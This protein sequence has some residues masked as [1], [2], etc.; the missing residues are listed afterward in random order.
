MTKRRLG[1][2]LDALFGG[3][4]YDEFEAEAPVAISADR[5]AIEADPARANL[6][7]TLIDPNP[8]QPRR[9]FDPLDLASLVQSIQQHGLIQPI[10]VRRVGERFQLVAGERR[11]R[12]A[13]EAGLAEVPARVI[14]ADDQQVFE[15]AI[16]ENLQRTDLNAI[17]K[18]RAFRD[19][20]ERFGSTQDE[21]ANR[22]SLDRS[23]VSNFIRLLDLPQ[24]I[25]QAVEVG[26]LSQGHARALLAFG[27]P[28]KQH[29]VCRRI[30]NECLSV[31]QVEALVAADRPAK[32]KAKSAGNPHRT[33]HVTELEGI[34]RECL[35]THVEIRLHG[36]DHGQ[37]IVDF[38]TND[39]FERI[40]E[41]LQISATAPPRKTDD[42]T[43]QV[44]HAPV[45]LGLRL[46]PDLHG[47]ENPVA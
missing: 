21:L 31:R 43:P 20:I 8:F 47:G 13:Q 1:R 45:V 7:V 44:D 25:Q 18:A 30:V 19:Y 42:Q 32:S 35:R 2:G 22:L 33:S 11:L 34:L 14:E 27:D 24:A 10:V 37:I 36:K 15:L 3:A 4:T 28:A 6:P 46:A 16:V 29:E 17:E 41:L 38:A 12:A 9:T 26:K 40:A 23:T 39:E 5:V